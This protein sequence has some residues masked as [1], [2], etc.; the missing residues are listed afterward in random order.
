MKVLVVVDETLINKIKDANHTRYVTEYGIFDSVKIEITV[1]DI[2]VEN[3]DLLSTLK[4]DFVCLM[5]L[6]N[7]CLAFIALQ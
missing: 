7:F 6:L 4:S 2:L 5:Y 3:Q 1:T